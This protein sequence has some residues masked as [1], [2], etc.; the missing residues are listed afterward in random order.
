MLPNFDLRNNGQ[1]FPPPPPQ[2]YFGS[3]IGAIIE[4]PKIPS[5]SQRNG[6]IGFGGNE[7]DSL[8]DSTL[9]SF[10]HLSNQQQLGSKTGWDDHFKSQFPAES[11]EPDAVPYATGSLELSA[12]AKPFIPKFTPSAGKVG[13]VPAVSNLIQPSPSGGSPWGAAAHVAPSA[14]HNIHN[15]VSP[16]SFNPLLPPLS[17]TSN[18]GFGLPPVYPNAQPSPLSF[19]DDQPLP[20]YLSFT[21]SLDSPR[22]KND[23]RGFKR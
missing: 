22:M 10:G 20:S 7:L 12:G 11:F 21:Q 15:T 9:S 2:Q 17:T 13:E 23:D 19:N 3:K 6:F 1:L 5:F 18:L 4:E 16:N 14:I 8:N